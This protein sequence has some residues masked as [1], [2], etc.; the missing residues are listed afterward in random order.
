MTAPRLAPSLD[1][2]TYKRHFMHGEERAWPETNCYVDLWIETLHGLGYDPVAGL[3]FTAATELEGD[4]FTFFKYPIADLE[5]LYGFY[6]I[7]FNPWLNMP[8]QLSEQV[9]LGRIP[10]VELDSF[11]LPDTAGTAYQRAHVKSSVA[12]E[13]LDLEAKRMNY[14]HG[15][16]YYTLAGDDFDGIFRLGD[17]RGDGTHLPPYIEVAKP[18][19]GPVLRDE[20]LT[21]ASLEQLRRQLGRRPKD[22]PFTLYRTKFERDLVWLKDADLDSFHNYAFATVRCFGANFELLGTYCKWLAER[23]GKN[24]FAEAAADFDGISS[25]SKT[26]QFKLARAVQGKRQVDFSPMMDELVAGWTR[27]QARLDAAV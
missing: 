26:M 15:A 22:N 7:E 5:E 12:V 10:V 27:G 9:G 2:A 21:Q 17:K 6:M 25:T 23:T 1:P 14:F 19:R 18:G 20:A 24:A 13:M 4:Q 11:Y 8:A 3:A 16:S